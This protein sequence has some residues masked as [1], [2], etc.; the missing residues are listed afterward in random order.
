MIVQAFSEFENMPA[1]FWALVKFVS[2]TLGYTQRGQKRVREYTLS[3]IKNLLNNYNIPIHD[4]TVFAVQKYCTM[5]AKL[6]NEYVQEML[7]DA[8]TAKEQFETLYELYQRQHYTCSWPMNKQSG[9]LKKVNYFTAM[10]NI[11]TEKTIREYTGCRGTGGPGFD[12]DPHGLVYIFDNENNIVGASSRR[13]DGAYPSIINPKIVWEIKEYYYATTF[14]SRV[15]DGVYETQLDGYEF[16]EIKKQTNMDVVHVFFIDAYKT[17]WTDGKSYLCR[18]V[19]ILN[20]GL[21]DE[22]IVGK[23]IFTRWPVLLGKIVK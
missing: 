21:V 19:D 17:W 10:I 22:V 12:D 16:R 2:E 15:A 7:M 9:A 18:I 1:S 8:Q 13:Y 23:E 11:L 3:E 5:R 20:A 4:D 6:L 14:G